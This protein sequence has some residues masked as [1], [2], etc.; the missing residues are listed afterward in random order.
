VLTVGKNFAINLACKQENM[1]SETKGKRTNVVPSQ[2]GSKRKTIPASPYRVQGGNG[3]TGIGS[4]PCRECLIIAANGS[5]N[6]R[7]RI[8]S[9]CTTSTGIPVP[10]HKLANEYGGM[11]LRLPIDDLNRLH[12]I[13]DTQGDVVDILYWR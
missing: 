11:Y 7:V 5:S 3:G 6:I 1:M 4:I 12:F 2:G 8:D 13:G 10:E 9:A